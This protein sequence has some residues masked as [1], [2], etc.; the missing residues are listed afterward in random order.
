MQIGQCSIKQVPNRFCFSIS[1]DIRNFVKVCL[2]FGQIRFQI[3][4][5]EPSLTLHTRYRCGGCCLEG[6]LLMKAVETIL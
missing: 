1:R 5:V 4:W 6:L 2:H 3:M